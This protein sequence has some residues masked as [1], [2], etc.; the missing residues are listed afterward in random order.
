MLYF[1][2]RR[3]GL[4]LG[5]SS[6]INVC[7]AAR[8]AREGGPGQVIVTILADGGQRYLSKLYRPE[9]LEERGLAPRA[10]GLEFLERLH[11]DLE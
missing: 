3:E 1:L 8:L 9:W 10:Q 7:G 5:S 6:A 11:S 4:F 2:L